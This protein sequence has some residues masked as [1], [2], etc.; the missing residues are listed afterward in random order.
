VSSVG[1]IGKQR[2]EQ[3]HAG[4]GCQLR[5]MPNVISHESLTKQDKLI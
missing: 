3:G 5:L 2:A 1:L 4:D